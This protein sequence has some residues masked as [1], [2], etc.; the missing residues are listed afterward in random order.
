M[1]RYNPSN[2]PWKFI[3]YILNSYCMYSTTTKV[4]TIIQKPSLFRGGYL[5]GRFCLFILFAFMIS[6]QV[7]GQAA[8]LDQ[9]RNGPA[10]DPSKNF[11]DNFDNPMHVNGNAGASNAHYVEGHSI[12]YRSLLTLL[13]VGTQY[14][15]VI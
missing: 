10:N 14:D 5:M 11:W 15:Y 4:L 13:T 7:N 3:L 6:S 9:I 1:S 12:S 2:E 8:N